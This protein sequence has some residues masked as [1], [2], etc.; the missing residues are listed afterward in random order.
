MNTRRLLALAAIG[1]YGCAPTAEIDEAETLDSIAGV[2]P[3]KVLFDPTTGVIPIPNTLVVDPDTLRLDLPIN[4]CD[5][6]ATQA[7]TGLYFNTLNGWPINTPEPPISTVQTFD[8]PLNAVVDPATAASSVFVFNL[9]TGAPVPVT[10]VA[11]TTPVLGPAPDCA[12]VAQAPILR[13]V[14]SRL[15]EGQTYAVLI[16]DGLLTDTGAPFEPDVFWTLVRPA[17]N[18]VDIEFAADGDAAVAGSTARFNVIRNETPFDPAIPE[19]AASIV[20]ID[21]LWRYHNDPLGPGLPGFLPAIELGLAQ[22]GITVTRSEMLHAFFF[23]TQDSGNTMDGARETSVTASL[24]PAAPTLVAPFT[25]PDMVT[26]LDP[27]TF[28]GANLPPGSCDDLPCDAVG[29][30]LIVQYNGTDFLQKVDGVPTAFTDPYDFADTG[31]TFTLTAWYFEPAGPAPDD[32][33]PVVIFGHGLGR[34]KADMLGIV[35]QL[36]ALG[37]AV[38]GI[39]WPLHGD[40]SLGGRAVLLET[41]SAE[42]PSFSQNGSDPDCYAPF[43]DLDEITDVPAVRDRPR[44]GVFDIQGLINTLTFCADNVCE[45]PFGSA[46]VPDPDPSRIGYIGQSLGGIIGALVT[47]NVPEIKASVLNVA[48]VDSVTTLVYSDVFGPTVVAGLQGLGAVPPT[49]DPSDPSTFVEDEGFLAFVLGVRWVWEPGDGQTFVGTLADG[50]GAAVLVQEVDGDTVVSNEG[51][52]ILGGLLGQTAVEANTYVP[53]VEVPDPVP[54][55]GVTGENAARIL[56]LDYVS[57]AGVNE[58][59]HGSLLVPDVSGDA[60]AGTLGLAQM[61]ADAFTF[62][63]TNLAPAQ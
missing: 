41:C 3:A 52:A 48:A 6:E 36:N 31:E 55:T 34:S 30:A 51:T 19:E 25:A 61:Q 5:D 42:N 40:E 32:G 13:L 15:E 56:W 53:S 27:P 28:I 54:S 39:D 63:V 37:F 23:S 2:V 22:A 58:Y 12:E 35:P 26:P 16:T 46:F 45:G 49:A 7:F 4:A 9:V 24:S 43:L 33:F 20:G 47:P 60:A 10:P 21:S 14:P 8:I 62:L 44:Q 38:V 57:S 11:A 17:I 18:P 50:S 59:S 29:K 1:L